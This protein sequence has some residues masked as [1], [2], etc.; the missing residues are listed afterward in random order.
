VLLVDELSLGLA[1][2]IVQ[3][4]LPTLRHL[5]LEHDIAVVLVEQHTQV[6]LS[7]ADR[8][9]VMRRGRIVLE[10]PAEELQARHDLLEASY[11]TE[12]IGGRA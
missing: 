7:V 5:A 8:A 9:Y 1:P 2:V 3:R 4:I 6:A 11:L 12:E 10:G